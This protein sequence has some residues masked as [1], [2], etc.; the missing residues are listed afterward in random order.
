VWDVV[1]RYDERRQER[2]ARRLEELRA[3][4]NA[5][6]LPIPDWSFTA[7]DETATL[8]IGDFWPVVATPVQFAGSGVVPEEWAGE[9][10]EL[11]LWLGG[12]GLLRLSTGFQGGL[13]PFHHSFRIA[14]S[15]QGGERIDVAAEVVP[16]GMFGSHIAEPR[17]ERAHFVVPHVDVRALERDLSMLAQAVQVLGDHEVVPH[18]LDIAEAAFAICGPAWPSATEVA[19]TRLAR[20]YVNTIGRGV[21][22]VPE[23]YAVE[24]YDVFPYSMPIWHLPPPP[25]D[26]EP[27]P[28]TTLQAVR[29]ARAEIAQR[30]ERLKQDYPPIGRLALTGHAHL[31]LAWLW[32]VAETRRKGR[33]T[34]GTML[35]LME[36]YPDFTFN[37]SSA[38]LYAWIEQDA[39]E[40]FARVKERV[41]EGRW[42]PVGGSWVEP[43]C[44]VTGGESFVRQLLYGQRAFERWFGKRARVAW[45]PDVFGFSGGIP[46][47]LRGAG[48]EGFF[49][50]KL[51]WNEENTFPHDLF[52]WEGIDGSRVTANM[53]RNLTPAHG[54]NGNIAPLDTVGTWRNFAGKRNHPESLLAFGWGD[55]AGGPSVRMLENYARIKEFPALPQLRMAHVEDYFAALPKAGLPVWVGE[56]YLEF[57]RG[58]LTTQAAVKALN[59]TS[60]HRLLEAEAFAA[61]ASLTGFVY[62]HDEL[63]A[64]WKTV[65]LNQ[66]HDIIPGSSIAEVYQD[67][68]PE[69]QLVVRVATEIRDAAL[70][71][72]GQSTAGAQLVV[73]NAAL[74]ARPLTLLLAGQGDDATVAAADGEPLATQPTEDGLLIHEPDRQAPGLG[75]LGLSVVAGGL[76]PAATHSTGLRAEARNGGALLEN[77]FLRVEIG[78]DGALHRIVDKTAADRDILAGR[79][80]Q[81]W[82]Y[83][84]KPR[85]YDA[86]DIEENYAQEGEEVGGVASIEVIET[87]PLRGAVR[88]RRV[89]RDSRI[90]QTYRLLTGSRRLDIATHIDWRERQVYLQARFPLNIHTHEATYETL[91][92]VVRR[93]THRNTSW[94]AARFEVSGHRF[95]DLS[96]PGYG[97]ALLTDAKY[98][99]SAHGNTMTLSLLRGSLYPDPGADEGEHRFT[100]SLFPHP[101]DWTEGDVVNEAFALNSPLIAVPIASVDASGTES[102]SFLDVDGLPLALGSLKRAEDGEGMILR[103]HEPHG[104]RGTAT[105]RFTRPLQ[106]IERVNLLEEPTEGPELAPGNDAMTVQIDVR[107]L[108]VVSLRLAFTPSPSPSALGEGSVDLEHSFQK[109]RLSTSAFP[110]LPTAVGEGAGG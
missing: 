54:Y 20:G 70:A 58:T 69:L 60:E 29:A 1:T 51:N 97:V 108:E 62:P 89:W 102:G 63:E 21:E 96:E 79:G 25:R 38:Q 7:G 100:Y 94:D 6:E 42:E 103:L 17:L 101:G 61:I 24:A 85:T 52:T 95:A 34:F 39:P 106:R 40:L 59:R 14:E 72:L 98:G 32:P 49:T 67:T 35:D 5:R 80:N 8:N 28:E 92:G 48:I 41:A 77:H 27:L 88:V 12:E 71:H 26:L 65:L 105:L 86:W 64:A 55:G 56:L 10:V 57:H 87:G 16:K 30:L 110:P 93:P 46:Q 31:D 3:W 33:R 53:F 37:Q 43:D 104:A 75:W 91:Y 81:L 99:Y 36:R 50:I 84:D 73:G 2:I 15:A 47:L 45:L 9:P 13:D 82:A 109:Q 23:S 18:L 19:Q 74:A 83:V 68:I 22:S 78:A 11:E 107:P 76:A 66:F 44:Q 4:R 90:E